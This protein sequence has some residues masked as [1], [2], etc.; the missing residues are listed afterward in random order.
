M[1]MRLMEGC[2]TPLRGCETPQGRIEHVQSVCEPSSPTHIIT[3]AHTT[4]LPTPIPATL[5]LSPCTHIHTPVSTGEW[6][7]Q[8]RTHKPPGSGPLERGEAGMRKTLECV[9]VRK[10]GQKFSTLLQQLYHPFGFSSLPPVIS[11]CTGGESSRPSGVGALCPRVWWPAVHSRKF[12][13]ISLREYRFPLVLKCMH[14]H[15]ST[16]ARVHARSAIP[17]DRVPS[18]R[19]PNSAA[20]QT[21]CY[22]IE[23]Y[24]QAPA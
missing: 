3:K 22:G 5:A 8:Q 24:F 13:T 14:V 4:L 23:N 17:H 19:P 7:G 15:A 21:L 6:V 18:G 9:S 2:Q 1:R 12:S 20:Q 11:E 16:Y 10:H